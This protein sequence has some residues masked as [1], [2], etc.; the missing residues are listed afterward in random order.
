MSSAQD[1]YMEIVVGKIREDRYPSGQLMD[2]VERSLASR[3]HL[4]AY[5]DALFE[6]VEDDHY[7]SLQMLDRIARLVP[8]I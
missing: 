5:L 2:R 8:L 3:E 6:K 1:R 4:E 7:P